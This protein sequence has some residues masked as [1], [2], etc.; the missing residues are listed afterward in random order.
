MLA[1]RTY[2]TGVNTMRSD[3]DGSRSMRLHTLSCAPWEMAESAFCLVVLNGNLFKCALQ[4]L[5]PQLVAL[6]GRSLFADFDSNGFLW[7][8][9]ISRS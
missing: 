5:L 1:V 8:R 9:R 2:G 4:S 3:A 7:L 6:S